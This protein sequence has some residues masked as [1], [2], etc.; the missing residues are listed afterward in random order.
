MVRAR[1]HRTA[2]SRRR[3]AGFSLL[4]ILVVI[5]ITAI[6]IAILLPSLSAARETANITRCLA[7][8]REISTASISYMED[9]GLPTQPWHLG[10]NHVTGMLD[11]V[12]EYVY[13]GFQTS[14]PHPLL[15]EKVDVRK[16]H[17]NYR[18]YNK[19]IAPGLCVGPVKTYVCPSDTFST[20]VTVQAPCVPPR[21]WKAPAWQLY[22]NSYAMNWNWLNGSPWS[23]KSAHYQDIFRMTLAGREMLQRK[24]GAPAS[25]FV[26]FMENPM[27]GYMNN[28]RPKDGSQG[29]PCSSELGQGWHGRFSRYSVGYLD[30]H[31]E[32]RFFDTRYSRDAG[33]NLWAEPLTKRGF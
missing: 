17:T 24:I 33:Y 18:P 32:H 27:N 15:G 1:V 14:A 2:A 23:D 11:F 4:E 12:S 16:V 26:L 21:L 7:N 10:Y 20:F 25:E 19:Y 22:G 3:A 30:G 9:E 28:S 13:G 29:E 8:L 6:M 31:A 5:A